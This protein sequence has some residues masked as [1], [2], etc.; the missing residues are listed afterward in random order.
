MSEFDKTINK[1]AASHEARILEA[2]RKLESEIITM[3][4]GLSPSDMSDVQFAVTLRQNVRGLVNTHYIGASNEIVEGYNEAVKS[5]A[6]LFGEMN[7]PI[8]LSS[9]DQDVI[10]Q[11]KTFASKS[12]AI[13]GDDVA[14][15]LSQALYNSTIAGST[16]GSLV[17]ALQQVL[18]EKIKRHASQMVHDQLMQF[19]STLIKK[20][21]DDA[22]AEKWEYTGGLIETSRAWCVSHVGRIMTEEEIRTEWSSHWD[23]KAAGDPFTVRGGYN[24]QH[25]W[26]PV[27]N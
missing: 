24:C 16:T 19:D 13:A 22:G 18:D 12:F 1:L 10:R 7:I 23:G 17:L 6:K 20:F 26:R 5:I 11:L 4:S 8:E 3:V 21:G 14:N 15:A 9:V 2:V 27:F 25:Q